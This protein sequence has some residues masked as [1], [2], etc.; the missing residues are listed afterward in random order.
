MTIGLR[1]IVGYYKAS[2]R[3]FYLGVALALPLLLA[4]CATEPSTPPAEEPI[5]VA[6]PLQPKRQPKK[7]RERRPP[8]RL[9]LLRLPPTIALRRGAGSSPAMLPT[10]S[11]MT[12]TSGC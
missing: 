7:R 10:G 12:Q 5:S 2:H 11:T 9:R 3:Y 8:P 1:L 4:A 6:T